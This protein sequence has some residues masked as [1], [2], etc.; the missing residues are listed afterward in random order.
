MKKVFADTGYWIALL[1]LNDELHLK[2]RNVTV[3][4]LPNR[5]GQNCLP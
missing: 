2:A 4:L 3:S 5:G 1:N